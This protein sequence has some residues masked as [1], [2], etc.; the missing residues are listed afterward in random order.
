M[1]S[2]HLGRLNFHPSVFFQNFGFKK[3][4][5][6]G[7][8]TPCLLSTLGIKRKRPRRRPGRNERQK[9]N[10]E[11]NPEELR[12]EVEQQDAGSG[13]GNATYSLRERRELM[14]FPPIRLIQQLE[15]LES[16]S[17]RSSPTSR[18]NSKL[19]GRR[20]WIGWWEQQKQFVRN[21]WKWQRLSGQRRQTE[22]IRRGKWPRRGRSGKRR[23]ARWRGRRPS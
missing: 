22:W 3:S 4:N 18:W 1:K 8:L 23:Q 2:V 19:H 11:E 17:N 7:S 16:I 10:Q 14:S 21:L 13:S 20:G 15:Q 5:F 12:V 9:D 6:V